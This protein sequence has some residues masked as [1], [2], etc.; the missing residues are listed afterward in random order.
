MN[1]ASKYNGFN[2]IEL[3][4]VV[5]IVGILVSIGYPLY[6][7]QVDRTRRTDGK[8]KLLEVL[9]AQERFYSANN[10]Y[11]TT[12]TGLGYAVATVPSDEGFY[13]ITAAQCAGP[14]ALTQCISLSAVPTAGGPQTADGCGTLSIDSRGNKAETGTLTLAQCW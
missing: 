14:I 1:R 11:I 7:D 6:K 13:G 4:I 3:M 12:L 2:L 9:E 10:T 8:T 5:A